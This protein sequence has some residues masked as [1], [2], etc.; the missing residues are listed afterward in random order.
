[1]SVSLDLEHESPRDC[2]HRYAAAVRVP[3]DK[4]LVGDGND[5]IL[6]FVGASAGTD[7]DAAAVG[8]DE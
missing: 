2:D 3:A 5:D 6:L 4:G 1:M 8:C 7:E